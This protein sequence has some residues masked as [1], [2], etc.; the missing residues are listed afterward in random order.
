M[1]SVTQ[2][3]VQ[4]TCLTPHGPSLS[5]VCIAEYNL[6]PAIPVPVFCNYDKSGKE[7]IRASG[8]HKCITVCNT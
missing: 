8:T 6:L 5:R 4:E 7:H 2:F 3:P 1:G